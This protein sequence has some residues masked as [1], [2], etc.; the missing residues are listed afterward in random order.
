M[1]AQLQGG[2]TAQ[3]L[4]KVISKRKRPE[5]TPA[6]GKTRGLFQ[7]VRP[8]PDADPRQRAYVRDH[9]IWIATRAPTVSRYIGS[10]FE[11]ARDTPEG[12]VLM[13]ELVTDAVCRELAR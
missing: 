11:G 6:D 8:D 3:A 12:Q 7:D 4:V 1:T 13:A 9:I 5:P 2:Q 10:A